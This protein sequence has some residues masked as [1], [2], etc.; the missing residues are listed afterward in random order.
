MTLVQAPAWLQ[1][2]GSQLKGKPPASAIGRHEVTLAVDDGVYT[3]EQSFVLQV[4]EQP[5]VL[6]ADAMQA[7]LM[8]LLG[9]DTKE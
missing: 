9:K 5:L 7:W 1:L 3:T 4:L 6:E 8:L 2:V